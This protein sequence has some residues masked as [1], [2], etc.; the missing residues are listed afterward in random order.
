MGLPCDW[1]IS[2]QKISERG[3]Y[4]LETGQW[5]DCKFIVGQGP[6]Q[7]TLKGHKLFLAMSSPVF[8]A[9][10]YGGMAEKNDPIQI[11]DAQP[12]AFKALLE[13]IYTDRVNLGS[14]ELA[15]ELCYCAKKYMLPSLVEECMQYLWFDLSPKIACRAYEFAKLF[16]EPVL[17]EKCLQII[18]TKTNE[19]LEESSWEEVELGTV[20]TVLEQ[21]D[22]EISS[23][24]E[25]FTAVER[26]AKAECVRKSLDPTDGKS[27]KSVIGNALSKIRFLTLTPQEFAESPGMSPLLTQDEAFAIL[28]NILC[29]EN[30]SPLPEGFSSD[31][32][33]RAKPLKAQSVHF[34]P[35]KH[36]RVSTPH[37][38]SF[39]SCT[40]W[41]STSRPYQLSF[42]VEG[43]SSN[44]LH[45]AP[46]MVVE[47]GV[48]KESGNLSQTNN[49]ST[50][51]IEGG[52]IREGPKYYCLRAIAHPTDCLNS[53]VLDCSVT[54]SVD[55]N[56]CIMG[57]QVPTQI[58]IATSNLHQNSDP[59]RSYTEILYA[60]LL[61]SDGSRLTYTHFTTKVN[62]GTLVEI[63]FNRAVYIQKHKIYRVGVVFNKIGWY[64]MGLC[65]Q[66]MTCDSVFFSF[67]IGNS[68]HSIRDGL[69][70]S[71]V[72]TY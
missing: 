43:E 38:N 4:L 72:F 35:S 12:D 66:H 60:H 14:F 34:F 29:T 50:A 25:L 37:T 53:N 20:I 70:R 46:P 44:S 23:E 6:H 31:T 69:I 22:L 17:M 68:D 5:S 27:L 41:P 64:P 28:M 19:V 63:T 13:Y 58:A 52:G 15:C 7:E 21:V 9:M 56:I 32:H 16:E 26:W 57:V 2:K 67:G 8:E 1:Q 65:T 71:I 62:V 48:R 39:S 61:D 54:F 42:D 11:R 10:F 18:C 24:L 55:K 40:F 49:P 51:I 33:N 47:G 30:K 59:E 3:K 36:R 45:N